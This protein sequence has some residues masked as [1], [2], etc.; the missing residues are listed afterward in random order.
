MH[1]VSLWAE[2]SILN[3]NEHVLNG[4]DLELSFVLEV[5]EAKLLAY[6][7]QTTLCET[8]KCPVIDG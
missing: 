3:L 2:V 5:L 6:W 4:F 8:L 1:L 7:T